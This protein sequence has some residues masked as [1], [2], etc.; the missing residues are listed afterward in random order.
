[1]ASI[2]ADPEVLADV[3]QEVDRPRAAPVQVQV[4]DVDRPA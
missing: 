2:S 3:A 4:V 1:L